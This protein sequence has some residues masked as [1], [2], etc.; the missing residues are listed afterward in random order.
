MLQQLTSP[1]CKTP[2]PQQLT[3]PACKTPVLQQLTSPACKTPMLQQLTSPA[4]KTPVLQQLTS[5]TYKT[6]VLQQLTSP[7]CKTPVLQQLTS[8]WG[9]NTNNLAKI[10][11]WIRSILH[12]YNHKTRQMYGTNLINLNAEFLLHWNSDYAH[13][14]KHHDKSLNQLRTA[15]I[16]KANFPKFHTL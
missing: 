1:T 14:L 13:Q 11:H 3:S 12:V 16:I 15:I 10:C 5:P 6:P 8:H 7:T 9:L 4:C 2:V